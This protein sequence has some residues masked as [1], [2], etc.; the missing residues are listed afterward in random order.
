[1]KPINLNALADRLFTA[2]FAS[3]LAFAKV[4]CAE[5]E[6]EGRDIPVAS[7]AHDL[8]I[9]APLFEVLLAWNV[10]NA[11]AAAILEATAHLRQSEAAH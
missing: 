6:A 11:N 4:E 10:A 8:D 2:E 3:R 9:P 5:A 7:L 1:M